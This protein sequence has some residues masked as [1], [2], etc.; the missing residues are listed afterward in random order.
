[1]PPMT[2]QSFGVNDRRKR[3]NAKPFV[4]REAWDVMAGT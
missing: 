4:V 2:A 1:M 3:A